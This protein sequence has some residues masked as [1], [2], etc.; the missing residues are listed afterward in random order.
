[1]LLS[2]YLE[3]V[4]EEIVPPNNEC[5]SYNNK[6]NSFSEERNGRKKQT[7][8]MGSQ[9]HTPLKSY[10]GDS[11]GSHLKPVLLSHAGCYQIGPPELCTEKFMFAITIVFAANLNKV[12]VCFF[13]YY[14]K[15]HTS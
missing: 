10:N 11:N 5:N 12:S 8:N 2:L 9:R 14:F 4:A 15:S 6:R 13:F 1:M 3:R 7:S